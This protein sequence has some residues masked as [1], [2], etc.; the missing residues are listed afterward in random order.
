[1]RWLRRQIPGLAVVVVIGSLALAASLATR[2]YE[3]IAAEQDARNEAARIASRRQVFDRGTLVETLRFCRDGWREQFGFHHE[4]VALA[5]TP[6]RVDGYFT[7]GHDDHTLRQV[8]CD[9]R[10]VERGPRVTH[11]LQAFLPAEAPAESEAK[12]EGAAW[13]LAMARL[14]ER[15]APDELAHEVIRHPITDQ[16]F[17]RRWEKGAEGATASTDPPDAPRFPMLV[18][19]PGFPPASHPSL[20]ALSVVP[21]FD[22]AAQPDAAFAVIAR[23]LPPGAGLSEITLDPD[24]IEVQIAHATKA[25]DGKPPAPF[26]EMEWD[27]FGVADRDWWYPYEIAGFGC[28]TGRPLAG[29]QADFAAAWSRMGSPPL[30]RAWYSCSPAYSNGHDGAWYLLPRSR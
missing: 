29:V 15:F 28:E 7:A 8:R 21:R 30:A 10:G 4:P 6:R 3:R 18:A 23:G 11:P 2:H 12:D 26:G 17:V 19:A 14:P 5:W 25:F 16:V 24:E 9:E 1:M 22:W 27:E 13:G 20:A